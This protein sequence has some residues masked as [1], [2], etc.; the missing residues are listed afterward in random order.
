M[1]S[2]E[3]NAKKLAAVSGIVAA[4]PLSVKINATAVTTTAVTMKTTAKT[5]SS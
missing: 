1:A 2:T 3:D 4:G 5:T